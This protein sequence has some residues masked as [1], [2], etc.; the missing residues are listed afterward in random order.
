MTNQREPFVYI[1]NFAGHDFSDA[2]QW[3][4]IKKVIDGYVRLDHPDRILY[5]V[6]EVLSLSEQKDWLLPSGLL[7]VNILAALA[8]YEK[9]GFVRLLVFDRKR[10]KNDSE[11]DYREIVITKKQIELLLEHFQ[12]KFSLTS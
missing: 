8:F 7:L 4:E 6:V 3:G 1:V 9:H 2:Q 12:E 5:E 11:P 10:A